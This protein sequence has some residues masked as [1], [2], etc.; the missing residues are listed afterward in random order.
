MWEAPSANVCVLCAFCDRACVALCECV[1]ICGGLSLFVLCV[2]V[3]VCVCVCVCV[4]ACLRAWG[5]Q[6]EK[7]CLR[8]ADWEKRLGFVIISSVS[9]VSYDSG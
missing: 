4:R 8:F 5:D 6:C 2:C 9:I 7:L 3:R 1:C